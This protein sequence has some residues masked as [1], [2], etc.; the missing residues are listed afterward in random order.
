MTRTPDQAQFV[1]AMLVNS[2]G[3]VSPSAQGSAGSSGVS[4]VPFTSAD[5]SGADAAVT[6]APTSG[7]KIVVDEIWMSVGATAQALTFKEE[8]S[9]TV[10]AGPFYVAANNSYHFAPG[11]KL[12]L[13][14]ANKKLMVRS[15]AS[16]NIS[17]FARYHSEA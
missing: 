7:Q 10:M 2:D 16:G 13:P 3:D 14:T 15:S 8:T 1:R 12:K 4:G 6:D 11:W 9:G 5:Q 17:I